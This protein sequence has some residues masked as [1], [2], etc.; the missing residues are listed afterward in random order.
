MEAMNDQRVVN[1]GSI[2]GDGKIA[3]RWDQE[4]GHVQ[5]T[6]YSPDA[7]TDGNWWVTLHCD[8]VNRMIKTLREARDAAF[9]D[10]GFGSIPCPS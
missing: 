1:F 5:L 9:G 3:L 6:V 10:A 7:D 2:L 8:E 4:C